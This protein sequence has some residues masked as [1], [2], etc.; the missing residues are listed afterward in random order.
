VGEQGEIVYGKPL[1]FTKETVD[2]AGF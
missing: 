2:K 1:I